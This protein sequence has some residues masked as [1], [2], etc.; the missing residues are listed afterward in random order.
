[1]DY[2]RKMYS[3]QETLPRRYFRIMAVLNELSF[4]VAFIPPVFIFFFD[5]R[6]V[7]Y[8][9]LIFV[10]MAVII[11]IS[12]IKYETERKYRQIWAPRSRYILQSSSPYLFIIISVPVVL[13]LVSLFF[14]LNPF[15]RVGIINALFVVFLVFLM[16]NIPA[17]RIAK[18]SKPLEDEYLNR[19]AK[20]IAGKLN[21]GS[22]DLYVIDL[23]RFKVANAGQV[24]AR[25]FSVFISNY[26]INNLDPD[27][28]VAVIAHEFAHAK[29]RH[30]LKNVMIGWVSMIVAANMLLF[31]FDVGNIPFLGIALFIG[32]LVILFG[33]MLF[34]LPYF[35]RKF[36]SEADIIATTV[37]DGNLLISALEKIA[38]LNLTPR[39]LSRYWNLDHPSTR[40]RVR[41]IKEAIRKQQYGKKAA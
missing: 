38:D 31:P 11:A 14:R 26:L 5:L 25:K 28:T 30:V 33:T 9:F 19:R 7:D 27:E 22:L 41:K 10:Q 8:L 36:E 3:G 12:S 35:Q 37:V 24:G 32:G 1:M 2:C 18:Y 23:D 4:L 29:Q 6:I 40:E 17:M 15:L 39:D 16:S 21:T 20:E 13:I 34:V